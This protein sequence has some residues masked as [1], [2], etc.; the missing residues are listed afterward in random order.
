MP[1]EASMKPKFLAGVAAIALAVGLA[2]VV[3]PSLVAAQTV[4]PMGGGYTNVIP[5]PVD[6]PTTKAIA[7]ALFKPTGAGPFP[8]VIYIVDCG[9]LWLTPEMALEKS[10]ITHFLAKGVA[11]LIVDPFTPRNEFGICDKLNDPNLNEKKW[12]QYA[13]RGGNDAVAAVKV[14][15]SVPEIDPN[16]IFLQGYSYGAGASL[17]AVD[18]KTPGAHD[19]K[20]AG[21]IAY[22]PYCLA[23]EVSVP[24]IILIGEMDDWTPAALCQ[25]VKDRPN[26]EVVVY[27]SAT[28]GFNNDHVDDYRGHHMVYDEKATQDAERR[29]DAFIDAHMP[30]K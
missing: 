3:L 17:F 9:G 19:A 25:A 5:I 13:T 14:L 7:G 23:T 24:A 8:A 18:T 21:V 6:D 15:R 28:H 12:A 30:P 20:I 11:T 10:V 1:E 27:P 2:A 29:A 22:Y 26:I 16:R 4:P